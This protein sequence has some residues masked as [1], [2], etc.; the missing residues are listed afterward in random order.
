MGFCKVEKK[1]MEFI[2]NLENLVEIK[3]KENE[4]KN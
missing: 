1:N 3:N 2:M 4:L